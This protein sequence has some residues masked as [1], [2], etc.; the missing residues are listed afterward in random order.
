MMDSWQTAALVLLVI[1]CA[2]QLYVN[3]RHENAIRALNIVV[4]T[5]LEREESML[6]IKAEL[7]GEAK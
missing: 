4:A 5:L 7:E 1:F 6:K 3:A 2:I